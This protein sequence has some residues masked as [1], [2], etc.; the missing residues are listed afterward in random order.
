MLRKLILNSS[1][2]LIISSRKC[3]AATQTKPKEKFDLFASV[4]IER[5]PIVSKK[6]NEIETEVMVRILFFF[7]L[8]SKKIKITFII[9]AN[10]QQ[11][12]VG[13]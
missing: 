13:K 4:L 10:A 11:N 2:T 7:R 12:R 8:N 5:L 9:S 1:K 6:L 3:S